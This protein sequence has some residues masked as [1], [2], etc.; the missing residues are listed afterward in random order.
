MTEQDL[1]KPTGENESKGFLRRALDSYRYD[2]I[3]LRIL[4]ARDLALAVF[5]SLSLA[6]DWWYYL[7][8][9]SPYLFEISLGLQSALCLEYVLRIVT[10]QWSGV[11]VLT[12]VFMNCCF[13]KATPHPFPKIAMLS[14]YVVYLSF[15]AVDLA[16]KINYGRHSMIVVPLMSSMTIC[17]LVSSGVAHACPAYIPG[18][19]FAQCGWF[20]LPDEKLGQTTSFFI[21][22]PVYHKQ[23]AE[24]ETASPDPAASATDVALTVSAPEK[25]AGAQN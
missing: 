15:Y 8:W 16:L 4:R 22:G 5:A 6:L 19:M 11:E 1:E 9:S 10:A 23:A 7:D 2:V 24:A 21:L 20:R 18:Y 25:D 3:D 17:G 14:R 13:A 12:R